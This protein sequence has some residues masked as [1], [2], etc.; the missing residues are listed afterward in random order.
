MSIVS[1]YLN[2][3]VS[4]GRMAGIAQ[5]GSAAG[6]QAKDR[7]PDTISGKNVAMQRLAGSDHCG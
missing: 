6:T 2:Q 7:T 1:K 3:W 4:P 5:A